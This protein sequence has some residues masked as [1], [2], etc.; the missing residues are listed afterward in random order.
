MAAQICVSLV[1]DAS[2]ED[3]I[4]IS[5]SGILPALKVIVDE[6]ELVP[7]EASEVALPDSPEPLDVPLP[8]SPRLGRPNA[9]GED[10]K[11][12]KSALRSHLP[13]TASGPLVKVFAFVCLSY[14]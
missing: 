8:G 5:K 14:D 3:K 12:L 9:A 1:E 4:L 10:G 13:A 11:P 7:P 6:P 2:E